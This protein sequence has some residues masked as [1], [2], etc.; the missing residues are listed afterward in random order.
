MFGKDSGTIPEPGINTPLKND[1]E[2]NLVSYYFRTE[3]NFS[4][5]PVGSE[6]D[7]SA[8]IDDGARFWLNGIEIDRVRLPNGV[9]EHGT[10]ASSNTA[11]RD[12]KQSRHVGTFDGTGKLVT[13]KNILAV[14]LHNRAAR[15]SDYLLLQN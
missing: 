8:V 10:G 9:I 14:D 15:S 2:G 3:F 12:E 5:D 1:A 4:D 6:I 11:A 13:G 7:I